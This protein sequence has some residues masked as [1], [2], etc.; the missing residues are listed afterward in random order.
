MFCIEFYNIIKANHLFIIFLIF[1][2][3][4]SFTKLT[5]IYLQH[6]HYERL[7]ALTLYIYHT[8]KYATFNLPIHYFQHT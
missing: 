5:I 2:I 3:M 6:L 7:Y 8:Q 4:Q 1:C